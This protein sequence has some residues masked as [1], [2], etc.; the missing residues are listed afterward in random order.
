MIAKIMKSAKSFDAVYYNEHKVQTQV[1]E[2]LVAANFNSIGV[3]TTFLSRSE[4]VNYFKKV[5]D[6]N[7]RVKNRQFHAVLSTKGKAHNA[8]ELK[9]LAEE[10]LHRMGY[11]DN[12]YL[13]YFHRDTENN[14]VHIVS[15]RVNTEGVRVDD[16]FE[17]KRSLE[18]INQ[19]M[20]GIPRQ[21][22]TGDHLKAS[23]LGYKFSTIAQL[24]MLLESKGYT[25]ELDVN[26]HLQ[27][28]K[29]GRL[30]T[31]ISRA[32]IEAQLK[33]PKN[34]Q[35]T[36]QLKA[37]FEKYKHQFNTDEFQQ[38]LKEKFGVEL[39]FH[40][41]AGKDKPY[42]YTIF[43]HAT[44][45]VFKGMEVMPLAEILKDKQGR[46]E[47][48]KPFSHQETI[49][50]LVENKAE[51]QDYLDKND[52]LIVAKEGKPYLIDRKSDSF[53]NISSWKN[54]EKYDGIFSLDGFEKHYD[55][56]HDLSVSLPMADVVDTDRKHKRG[57]K[58]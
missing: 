56:R 37:V 16:S 21:N 53:Q 46:S 51:M 10:Y 31:T 15:T 57:Y 17:K 52:L 9:T 41:A 2:L 26:R 8:E 28:K 43:D 30:V 12:P 29:A 25:T 7:E 45:E 4:I 1:A 44:K 38:F 22:M 14:H 35:R 40:T 32:D 20:Q 19:I 48:Q 39:V 49:E 5:S 6:L 18:T 33:K 58:R 24:E 55:K 23:V 42:G 36:K 11:G 3:N 13:I 34:T 50:N 54:I 27:V 47:G